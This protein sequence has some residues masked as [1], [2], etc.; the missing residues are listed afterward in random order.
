MLSPSARSC[1]DLHSAWTLQAEKV[2]WLG[3]GSF[4]PVCLLV[5]PQSLPQGAGDIAVWSMI[6]SWGLCLDI[7]KIRVT[8]KSTS[9]LKKKKST[10]LQHFFC[11]YKGV[12]VR[13][14]VSQYGRKWCQLDFL[15]VHSFF[16]HCLPFKIVKKTHFFLSRKKRWRENKEEHLSYSIQTRFGE[17]NLFWYFSA[18]EKLAGVVQLSSEGRFIEQY[19]NV[20]TLL[21]V[22]ISAFSSVKD[23]LHLCP[24]ESQEQITSCPMGWVFP[25]V[26]RE[27]L[28][29]P[30]NV[31]PEPCAP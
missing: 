29:V 16:S 27:T 11:T 30:K 12:I 7:I 20:R 5:Q 10:F 22:F 17:N 23:G 2:L 13:R 1:G 26:G 25:T 8:K 21:S 19:L 14:G 6:S 9:G 4:I 15:T 28:L 3:L 24:G 18:Y 31:G